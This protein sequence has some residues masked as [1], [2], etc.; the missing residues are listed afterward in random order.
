MKNKICILTT[1][2]L[3]IKSF[4][5]GQFEALRH[6][7]FEVTVICADDP[8][9]AGWLPEGV[10]FIPVPFSRVLSPFSDLAVL[11]RLYTIFRK[12]KFS[13][14]Q[15]STPKASLLGA[16]A[17]FLANAPARIYIL[18]GLYYMGQ[19]GFKYRLFKCIEKIICR[20][21]HKILPISHEMVD[22]ALNEGLGSK[23]KYEVM[24][25]GSACGVDLDRFDPDKWKESRPKI[26]D[27]FQIPE[28]GIVIGTVARLTGDKGINELVAAFDRI[29]EK[30]SGIY[31][32]LVG[33]EEEKDRL[34][35]ETEQMIRNNPRVRTT[36]WQDN[37]LPFYAAMDIF[38]LPTYREGFGEVNLEAQAM[39]LPVI[40]TDTIGPRE[41]IE[42]GTTGFLVE[43]KSTEALIEP[44]TELIRSPQLRGQMG[45]LGRQRVMD[46]FDRRKMVEAIVQHRL[47]L[48]RQE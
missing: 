14:I 28:N 9:L 47:S 38:C 41:S 32:L 21:S 22:F 26:R 46:K 2:S 30:I 27:Q 23:E 8:E 43:P 7:G 1:I 44:L 12:E 13:I 40:S 29:C 3:S 15:Y 42:K 35:P 16:I 45:Q 6:A 20:L 36:G 48:L 10:R 5:R 24:L 34:L 31:L 25:N 33:M 4:Y 18:W 37:P 17:A 19:L 39:G 11:F